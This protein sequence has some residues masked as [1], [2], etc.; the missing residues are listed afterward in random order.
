ME[1]TEQE[2]LSAK[3]EI[4]PKITFGFTGIDFFFTRNL[5]FNYVFGNS[6]IKPQLC[7]DVNPET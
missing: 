2:V 3:Y 4:T 1:W 7:T 6:S 5:L